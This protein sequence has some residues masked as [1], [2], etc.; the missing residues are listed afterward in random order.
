MTLTV[1]SAISEREWRKY[2]AWSEYVEATRKIT[3]Y[4]D[5]DIMTYFEWLDYLGLD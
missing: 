4:G 1:E 3:S 2:D 5:E